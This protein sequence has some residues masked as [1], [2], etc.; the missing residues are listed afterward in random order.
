MKIRSFDIFDTC[1]VRACGEPARVFDISALMLMPGASDCMVAEYS[2][3][4]EKCEAELRRRTIGEEIEFTEIFKDDAYEYCFGCNPD[5]M[6]STEMQAEKDCLAG[7][8]RMRE[9]I[10]RLRAEGYQIVYISD[11]YLPYDFVAQILT[12][13]GFLHE[14]DRL[15]LS[16][17]EKV[18]KSTGNLY[19]RIQELYGSTITEWIHCGDNTASDIA[20]PKRLG[21][22]AQA[23]SHEMTRSERSIAESGYNGGIGRL[24]ASI[25]KATRLE[26]PDDTGY[27]FAADYVAPLLVPFVYHV[28]DSARK[29]GIRTLYFIARDGCILYAISR[30]LASIFPDIQSR[31]IYLSRSALYFPASRSVDAFL[32]DLRDKVTSPDA[33]SAVLR[34]YCR[35][36]LD[37]ADTR[38]LS[39]PGDL[40][41]DASLWQQ[42]IDEHGRQRELLTEYLRQSGVA[43]DSPERQAIVDLRGT[44]K[45]L[46]LINGLLDDLGCEPVDGFYLELTQGRSH[47]A[48]MSRRHSVMYSERLSDHDR[49]LCDAYALLEAY[50]AAA[51]HGRTIGYERTAGHIIPVM[52]ATPQDQQ[53]ARIYETNVIVAKKW[54]SHYLATRAYRHNDTMLHLGLYLL[55]GLMINPEYRFARMFS[56]LVISDSGS[57]KQFLVKKLTLAEA[58]RG[59]FAHRCFAWYNA[60]F[61]F[62]YG[63]R[64]F[65]IQRRLRAYA[66]RLKT[67]FKIR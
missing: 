14:G 58:I 15:F 44:A 38:H 61:I 60:S 41:A 40:R 46:D 42:L 28:L 32:E 27:E 24:M 26:L 47:R 63:K 39:S 62:T 25:C 59:R 23:V 2:L 36:S 10:D 12:R 31:Y 1:L 20:V 3:L 21:I 52:E 45:T 6:A 13:E 43:S 17:R 54:C 55:K 30:Q 29:K 11:M 67:C 34:D 65:D 50:Y 7:V 57:D 33:L 64:L 5:L 16:S 48:T 53:N 22:S 18:S 56:S 9:K 19:K 35:V 51:D 37:S 4:R 49:G 66:H 8:A